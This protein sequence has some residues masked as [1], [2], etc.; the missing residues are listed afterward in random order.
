M[1]D[2][3]SEEIQ[4]ISANFRNVA[5]RLSRTDYSQ[6]DANLKRF[7]SVIDNQEIIKDFIEQHN[8]CKFDIKSIIQERDWISPFEISPV[9]DEE[10]SLEYQ[11]LKYSVEHFGGDFTRLYG[12]HIYTS[13]KSTTNDEMRKFIEHIIDPLIDFIS[14]HLRMCYDRKIREE[15]KKRPN[16]ANGITANYSTVVV[17]NNIEGNIGNNINISEEVKSDALDL[18]NSIK[19]VVSVAGNEAEDDILELLKQ[20]ELDIKANNKPK[21]G[22]LVA[23]KSICG[24]SAAVIT[25]INSLM[26]LFGFV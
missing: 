18:I 24:G 3:S 26:K 15:G 22:F 21:K 10:I 5:R 4:D 1:R 16:L 14:E 17:A 25:L 8:N 11:M 12:T 9:I 2:Y 13:T 20:I 7:M 23:L 19:E 6:C